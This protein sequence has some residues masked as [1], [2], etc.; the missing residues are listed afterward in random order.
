MLRPARLVTAEVRRVGRHHVV[1]GLLAA[2][3]ACHWDVT[4]IRMMVAL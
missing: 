4:N 1:D 3:D 2:L